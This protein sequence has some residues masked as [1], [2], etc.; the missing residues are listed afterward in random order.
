M[1]GA[2]ALAMRILP[3]AIRLAEM[4][5]GPKQGDKKRDAALGM[6]FSVVRLADKSAD[7]PENRAKV[8]EAIDEVVGIMNDVNLLLPH[9]S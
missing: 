8:G 2:I 3:V 1:L 4:L 7:T 9:G 6:I 5:L